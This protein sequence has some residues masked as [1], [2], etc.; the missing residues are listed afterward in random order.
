MNRDTR[1]TR[2]VL[3]LLLLTAVTLL[4]L[5]FRGGPNSP[6]ATVRTRLGD[7]FGPVE[8]AAAAVTRPV[9]G[10]LDTI[11]SLGEGRERIEELEQENEALRRDVRTSA[12]DKGRVEQ[13]DKLLH[14]SGVGRY[15]VVPARV[16]A[17]GPAQ[18]F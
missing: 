8:R 3:A 10:F 14:L 9:S 1:R 5:D 17:V 4:V 15:R 11:G 2:L 6:L 7:V 12:V 13:L 16:I 18:G